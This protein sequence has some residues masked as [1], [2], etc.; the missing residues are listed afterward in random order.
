MTREA[1]LEF[2]RSSEQ[3][4]EFVNGELVE[5]E[6]AKRI[7][8][9][10]VATIT[11][12]L[13]P[14]LR[15]TEWN[16]YASNL[17]IAIDALGNYRFADVS[18]IRGEASFVEDDITNDATVLFEILSESTANVDRGE[19]FAEY[20]TLPSLEEYV[21]V[22]TEKVQ[23]EVF[24]RKTKREWDYVILDDKAAKLELKSIGVELLLADIYEGTKLV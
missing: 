9:L 1:Y 21:L 4:Y 16:V 18:V 23:V 19:K 14:K 11:A 7:H 22:S 6:V 3:R 8:E 10:L 2:E 12:I 20:Q 5:V 17:K 13:F 15:G 24:R